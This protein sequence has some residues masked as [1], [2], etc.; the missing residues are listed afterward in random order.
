MVITL[1]WSKRV[2]LSE[3]W[4]SGR[5]LQMLDVFEFRC[6]GR[7]GEM[8]GVSEILVRVRCFNCQKIGD[9]GDFYGCWQFSIRK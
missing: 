9:V 2:R 4:R 6:D 5:N 3:D 1:R 7:S 8:L